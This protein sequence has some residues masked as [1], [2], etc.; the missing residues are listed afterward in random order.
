MELRMVSRRIRDGAVTVLGD[1][2]QATGLWKYS[3]WSE[4]AEHLGQADGFEIEELTLAYRVPKEIMDVALPVLEL[5]APSIRPPVAF[6]EGDAPTW[7]EVARPDLVA[8]VISRASAYSAED[9]TVAIIAPPGLLVELREELRTRHVDFGDGESGELAASIELLDP[10]MSKGLEFDHVY[11]VEPSVIMR[12]GHEDR[13]FQELY[14]A[15]TRATRSLTCVHSEPLR[16]PLALAKEGD[17]GDSRRKPTAP[18]TREVV[19]SVTTP[20][21]D[22]ARLSIEE[23]FVLARMRS[24]DS[25][26]ALARALLALAAGADEAIVAGAI[27]EPNGRVDAARALV[28]AARKLAKAAE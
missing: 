11:L 28:E 16:W 21:G 9:G 3:A 19:A 15:L 1:L 25:A 14:V 12:E 20:N 23:A 27:I 4:I 17:G 13:R 26:E 2:A 5:T 18:H 10:A 8:D 7:H 6:R 22:S 24:L